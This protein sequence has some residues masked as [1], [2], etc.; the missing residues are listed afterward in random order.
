MS[1]TLDI[2]QLRLILLLLKIAMRAPREVLNTRDFIRTSLKI[3]DCK[4]ERNY[5]A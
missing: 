3:P 2:V 5:R 1:R 4:R